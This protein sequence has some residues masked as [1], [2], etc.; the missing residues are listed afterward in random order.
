MHTHGNCKLNLEPS[1]D[2]KP[3]ENTE[4]SDANK[5]IEWDDRIFFTKAICM[6]EQQKCEDSNINQVGYKNYGFSNHADP[7]LAGIKG[8]ML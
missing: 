5:Q 1:K 6:Q 3:N 8:T 2:N 4:T 7:R